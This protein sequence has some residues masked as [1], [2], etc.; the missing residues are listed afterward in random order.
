MGEAGTI[1]SVWAFCRLEAACR[2]EDLDVAVDMLLDAREGDPV[3]PGVASR[4]AALLG[5]GVAELERRTGLRPCAD[6]A[7]ARL[8]LIEAAFAECRRRLRKGRD[9][10]RQA[11]AVCAALQFEALGDAAAG[12]RAFAALRADKVEDARL[13][14]ILR[15]S[16]PLGECVA[17]A[18]TRALALAGGSAAGAEE[19]GF[20]DG[21]AQAAE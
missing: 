8:L 18:V 2:V 11:L 17:L 3:P 20:S 13:A 1:P 12:A 7:A 5:Y 15:A 9:G 4:L 16:L 6:L 10:L 19:S 14:G 21:W